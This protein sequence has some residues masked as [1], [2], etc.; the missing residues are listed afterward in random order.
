MFFFLRAKKRVKEEFDADAVPVAEP[1]PALRN[2]FGL[3]PR[4]EKRIPSAGLVTAVMEGAT[5]LRE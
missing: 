5:L 4:G 1:A 2:D 3:A